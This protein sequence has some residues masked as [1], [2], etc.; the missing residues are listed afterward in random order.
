MTRR[1]EGRVNIELPVKIWGLDKKGQPFTEN[2]HTAD[3]IGADARLSGVRTCLKVGDVIGAQHA[4]EKSRYRIVW[5]RANDDDAFDVGIESADPAH[6][7]WAASH[8]MILQAANVK[9][10]GHVGDERRRDQRLACDGTA[11]IRRAGAAPMWG[12]VADISAG[13]CYIETP[14]PLPPQ[15]E[16]QLKLSILNKEFSCEGKVRASHPFVGMGVLFTWVSPDDRAR[17]KDVLTIL[18]QGSVIKSEPAL[19]P[20][21]GPIDATRGSTIDLLGIEALIQSGGP[22][23]DSRVLQE[24]RSA[25]ERARM[26]ASTVQEWMDLQRR[27]ADPFALLAK[28]ESQCIK[29]AVARLR[30]IRVDI[31]SGA[32]QVDATGLTE[33]SL[34]LRRSS[35]S[36]SRFLERPA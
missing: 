6:Y 23:I 7:I 34:E 17:L 1:R 3:V 25:M 15:M 20:S 9:D 26:I 11:E 32:N 10:S 35:E 22:G 31:E 33:L 13:G 27:G 2:A 12:R 4:T 19:I 21:S 14:Q 16:A 30:E 29:E 5:V 36:V 18:A 24:F 28:L 8:Q